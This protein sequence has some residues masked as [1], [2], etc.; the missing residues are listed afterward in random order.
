MN[1]FDRHVQRAVR[2]FLLA[3]AALLSWCVSTAHAQ[4]ASGFPNKPVKLIVP[5]PPGGSTDVTMR[6]L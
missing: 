6:V 2:T 3:A 1:H 4:T 5:W